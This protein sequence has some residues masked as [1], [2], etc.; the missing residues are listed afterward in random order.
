[1]DE[2]GGLRAGRRAE[3]LH[4]RRGVAGREHGLLVDER[5]AMVARAFERAAMPLEHDEQG[6]VGPRRDLRDLVAVRRR[7]RVEDERALRVTHVHAI[8]RQTSSAGRE[9][10]CDR[11]EGQVEASMRPLRAAGIA[12]GG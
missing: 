1:M 3:E 11:P 12:Q 2:L 5:V 10:A 8:E 9:R 4:R 7:Q 6:S